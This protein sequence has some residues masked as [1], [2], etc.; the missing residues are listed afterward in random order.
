M[1]IN[2]LRDVRIEEG[3]SEM[4]NEAEEFYPDYNAKKDTDFTKY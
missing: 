2:I 3:S 1:Y 4:E